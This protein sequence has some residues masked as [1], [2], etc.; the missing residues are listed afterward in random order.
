MKGQ[1]TT[2]SLSRF[3]T[4]NERRGS[5]LIVFGKSKNDMLCPLDWFHARDRGN[6]NA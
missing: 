3:C 6:G 4:C 5:L 1:Q 2:Q